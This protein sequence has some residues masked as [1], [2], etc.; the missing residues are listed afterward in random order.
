MSISGIILKIREKTGN[1]KG[2]VLI[3]FALILPV[4]LSFCAL[5]IDGPLA[6]MKKARLS[7]GLNEAVLAIAAVNNQGLSDEDRATNRRILR[8]Y[9]RAYMPNADI[10]MRN[11]LVKVEIDGPSTRY[12]ASALVDIKTVLPLDHVGLP[13]FGKNIALGNTGNVVKLAKPTPI[14]MM[15][16][17]DFSRS[18]AENRIPDGT[19]T[20]A[21]MVQ[22]VVDNILTQGLRS[23]NSTFGIVPYDIGVPVLINEKNVLNGQQVGCSVQFVPRA[24]FRIDYSFW[25]DKFVDLDYPLFNDPAYKWSKERILWKMDKAMSDYYTNMILPAISSDPYPDKQLLVS[26]GYCVQNQSNETGMTYGKSLYSCWQP[27]NDIFTHASL[28]ATEYERVIRNLRSMRSPLEKAKGYRSIANIDSIDFTATIANMFDPN[29]VT[30][31]IQPWAPNLQ[32]YRTFGEMCQSGMGMTPEFAPNVNVIK[33]PDGYNTTRLTVEDAYRA[34]ARSLKAGTR[35]RTFLIPLTNNDAELRAFQT[36]Q[37]AGG[38]DTISGLLRAVPELAKGN[39]NRKV[40]VIIS[41]G[42]D[43]DA[44]GTSQE[45]NLR[46]TREFLINN[47]LCEKIKEGFLGLSSNAE[48]SMYFISLSSDTLVQQELRLWAD[49]CVGPQNVATADSWQTLQSALGNVIENETGFFINK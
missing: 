25:A 44:F 30:T 49:Y 8:D 22:D 15:L 23:A 19:Q 21:A 46:L 4:Y 37:P 5:A 28:N 1:Q 35:Q 40:M 12:E 13:G 24:N 29:N 10:D 36:M 31:F 20:R 11:L 18:M 2:A 45:D 43:S 47:K 14:D 48:F 7:D 16:V 6:L 41:D 26:R 42:F 34:I 9:L 33:E 38:T 39:N 27:G 17:V 3:M 32:E